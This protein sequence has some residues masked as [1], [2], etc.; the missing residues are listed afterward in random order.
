[1]SDLLAIQPS[2]FAPLP[3]ID[4]PPPFGTPREIVPGIVWLRL[5]L[6]Q[7]FDHVNVYLF[8]ERDGWAL[9]DTGVDGVCCRDHWEAI[10]DAFLGGRG[11][12]RIIGSHFH[13][14]HVGLA[15]WFHD[16]FA[17][18]FYMT[19]GDYLLAR[20][21]QA[22]PVA[23]AT[24]AE[25]AHY[26]RMGFST[27]ETAEIPSRASD[28]Q[29]HMSILPGGFS[30]LVAGQQL[31]LA[32]RTWQVLTVGGHAP[33]MVLLWCP[34]DRLL[35]SSDQILPYLVP[36][37]SV[38]AIEPNADSLGVYLDTLATLREQLPDDVL[39]L[40]SH[41][42]PF[43]GLHGRIDEIERHHDKRMDFLVRRCENSDGLSSADLAKTLFR[44]KLDPTRLSYAAEGVLAY[45]HRLVRTGR[46]TTACDS[47]GVVRFRQELNTSSH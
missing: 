6:P 19:M 1:M 41:Y 11:P 8:E 22:E 23:A 14:D 25:R 21:L 34:S 27:E 36:G 28:F 12:T 45:L 43:R 37:V 46:L 39:V 29:R 24:A 32:G 15:G 4:Q 38:N 17:M 2:R 40:P 42:S 13:P 3:R 31:E 18:P 5:P 26:R 20:A 10:F 7:L 16:R 35:L 33:E 44:R 47:N 30:R 9:W